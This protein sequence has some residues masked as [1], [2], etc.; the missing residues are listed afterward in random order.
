MFTLGFVAAVMASVL[1]GFSF[2]LLVPF[3][4]SLFGLAESVPEIH[5]GVEQLIMFTAGGLLSS[6]D[7]AVV[8]RNTV[9]LVLA[10]IVL[11]NIAVFVA[12][13]TGAYIEEGVAR[14]LR[15]Q[16]YGRML[17]FR[18]RYFER[19][20]G[21]ELIA[22]MLSDVDEA[23]TI[24][25]HALTSVLR[26]GVLILVYLA[27]LF[28][29]S[30]RLALP[31]LVLA[32]LTAL[33]LKPVLRGMRRR[34]KSALSDRGQMAARMSETIQGVR[35][36]KA[37]GMESYER[38]RFFAASDKYFSGIVSSQWFATMTSPISETLAA[39][40]LVGLLL[41]AGWTTETGQAVRPEIFV[42]F[43]A[44]TIRL[45]P[46]VKSLS[47]FPAR[48]V[49]ALSAAERVFEV[50]DRVAD[51]IDVEGAES[52]PGIE[53]EIRFRDVWFSYDGNNWALKGVNL[54]IEKGQVAAIV[55]RSGAGKSTLVD[56]VPR[57]LEPSRGSVLIDGVSIT[58][59]SNATL[60]KTMGIVSQETIV[61]NDTVAHNIAYGEPS[62]DMEAVTA[63]ARAAN[64]H[65]FISRLPLGYDTV[66]G[67]RGVTLSGGERQRLA[68]ARALFRDPPILIL[69][70]ATSSLD[71]ESERLVQDAINGLLEN[72]TVLVV[73]HRLTTVQHADLVVVMEDG[74]VVESGTHRE[75]KNSGGPYERLYSLAS[76]SGE[77]L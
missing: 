9:L 52:F 74:R 43:V 64:A 39:A 63:A 75:L 38:S 60:R 58:A 70:E 36:V 49:H 6:G 46:A 29:L 23:K 13:Y 26:N 42:T 14:D 55:G 41:G 48:A 4:R 18:L 56:M 20:K 25:S 54:R 2:T 12:S 19:A 27:I 65:S 16:M 33:A 45:L 7:P 72:R 8:L 69:D 17:G 77:L 68:I 3:L 53:N 66:L 76:E 62:P 67:E 47:R 21:G 15:S 22:R 5:T 40:L 34:L 57:F 73:A 61:L 1:D 10:V 59:Y 24:V 31:T 71:S 30:W 50:I 44:V 32:P 35:L 37:H 11:K 51:D 28:S